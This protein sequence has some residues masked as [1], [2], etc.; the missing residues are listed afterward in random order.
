MPNRKTIKLYLNVGHTFDHLFMLIFPTV[1]LAISAEWQR[2]YSELLPLSLPGFIAFGVFSI[3]AGWLADRW[4][5]SGMMT[6]FFF[7]IGAASIL[8][9]LA[10][11]EW[12]I[13]AGLALVGVFAAIYHPVGMAMLVA[14][15]PKIGRTGLALAALIAG[16]LADLWHW[17]AAF[18]VPGIV[19]I[20]TGIG[21]ALAARGGDP[22]RTKAKA[23]AARLP[24]SVLMRVF[25]V[26]VVAT[27][28]GGI[29]FNATTVS[30]PKVFD[31]RLNALTQST[32]GIGL[33]VCMVYLIAAMAQ[34]LMGWWLDRRSLKAVFVP[35]VA[36]QVPLL[37][38]AGSL[39]GYA[40]LACAVAMMFFVFGQIPIN[41]AMIARYTSDEWRARAYSVRYV[42]SFAAS[43]TAV[44]LIAGLYE[45]TGNFTLLFNIL[46]ALAACIF[47]AALAF[48]S[49][50][51]A[52]PAQA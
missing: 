47:L 8:T 28:C 48:P 6:L 50:A 30:M 36:L 17:R 32:L 35:V 40:M 29:I 44:P 4:S 15:E 43:A 23:G 33:L 52:K 20:A 5:R 1:V 22:V 14:N 51:E 13:S 37:L 27:I 9:G 26:V 31:E 24:R 18:F 25:A 19:W 12:Q 39:Q 11:N 7:G 38:A 46:A 10:Q 34:L 41:D 16:A 45:A 2:P 3:P 21:F 49:Q 42:L